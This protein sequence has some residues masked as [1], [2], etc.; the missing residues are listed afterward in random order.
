MGVCDGD[1]APWLA[2]RRAAHADEPPRA[3]GRG[4]GQVPPI[5]GRDR[6]RRIDLRGHQAGRRH[7]SLPGQLAA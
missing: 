3:H 2:V 7:A 4:Q 6:A 5:C 1:D